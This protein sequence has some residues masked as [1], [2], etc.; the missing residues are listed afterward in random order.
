MNNNGRM[1]L[2]PVPKLRK[3]LVYETNFNVKWNIGMSMNVYFNY[4]VQVTL[5]ISMVGTQPACW[6]TA[7]MARVKSIALIPVLNWYSFID[8]ERMK[9][10]FEL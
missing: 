3:K 5:L 2:D 7:S 8:P 9:A 1:G 4:P 6:H 10:K